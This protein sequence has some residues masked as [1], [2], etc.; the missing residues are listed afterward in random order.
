MTS[1]FKKRNLSRYPDD[2]SDPVTAAPA[3]TVS[4]PLT[5]A[6]VDT[7]SCLSR[8]VI[9]KLGMLTGAA[10]CIL[11]LVLTGFLLVRSASRAR[12]AA[13]VADEVLRLHVI[14][15]SD[16]NEDQVLKLRVRD[17][18]I[19]YMAGYCE[20]FDSA[21][22]AAAFAEDHLADFIRISEDVICREGFSYH[23]NASV[24]QYD[25]PDKT[26][27]DLTF[28]AGSYEA[29]RVEIGQA[30]GQNWWC[31]LYPPLCLTKEGTA[32]VP[33]ESR[34]TLK[35]ALSEEDYDML[36]NPDNIRLE[37]RIVK[38]WKQLWE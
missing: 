28:P 7:V 29:V 12:L 30:Q 27:D 1:F 4:V 18:L 23:V 24:G 6:S 34:Q 15:N 14:A 3:R 37:F 36:K 25:F 22:S 8:P 5:D 10:V 17:A 38:W 35:E 11:C 9:L 20:E 32:G 26:Y 33:E 2:I 16:S 21:Q 13:R 19:T 31:V